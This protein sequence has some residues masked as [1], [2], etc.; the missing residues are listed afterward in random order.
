MY[1]SV[2]NQHGTEIAVAALNCRSH[3][4]AGGRRVEHFVDA[5]AQLTGFTG[6]RW[7]WGGPKR[8]CV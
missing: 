5:S 7:R 3:L 2:S 6:T 8:G 1:M 4:A